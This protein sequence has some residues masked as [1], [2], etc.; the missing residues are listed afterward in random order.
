MQ[1]IKNELAIDHLLSY[2]T[3]GN[4]ILTAMSEKT[5]NRFT[6][7]IKRHPDKS[8]KMWFVRVRK[9]PDYVLL[10]VIFSNFRGNIDVFVP[11]KDASIGVDSPQ[12][13]AFDYLFETAKFKRPKSKKLHV[14][15][16]GK[17]GKCG[18]TL[19]DPKSIAHG[20]GPVCG[21]RK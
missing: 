10:G 14:I 16:S 7:K 8:K 5:G 13:K 2:I 21:N 20:L 19:T 6:Y 9:G 17:C 1:A 11:A 18:R 3:A 4:A 12:F 15:H